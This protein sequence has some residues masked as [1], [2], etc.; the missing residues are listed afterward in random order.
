MTAT[1]EHSA[2]RDGKFTLTAQEANLADLRVSVTGPISSTAGARVTYAVQIASSGPDAARNVTAALATPGLEST[3][4]SSGGS[5]GAVRIGDVTIDGTMWSLRSVA[6]GGIVEFTVTGTV[7]LSAG[8]LVTVLGGAASSTP[9]SV[10]NHQ[11][12]CCD[13][14]RHEARS[15]TICRRLNLAV[16]RNVSPVR[17]AGDGRR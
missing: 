6:A 14:S 4:A 17:T 15:R 13:D 3:Q 10:A 7:A 8:Q 9:D 5:C 11:R 2:A 1:Q 16:P 12:E